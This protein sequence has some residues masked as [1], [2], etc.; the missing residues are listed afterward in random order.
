[1][2]TGAARRVG[3]DI[4]LALAGKGYPMA[5]H[6]RSSRG[7]AE[8]LAVRIRSAGV[9]CETFRADLERAEECARLVRSVER[10][11]G[12]IAVLVNSAS[13]Y[14]G[15]RWD[16]VKRD[17]W[18]RHMHVNARAPFFCAQAA[19]RSMMK[20]GGGKIVNI[21]DADVSRPY[22]RYLPYLVSKNA[23]AGLTL[24][25]AKELAPTVQVNGVSPGAVLLPEGW[26]KKVRDAIIR[27]T[28]ARKIGSPADIAA[29]V[30]FFV[31]SSDFITG[32]IL[33]VDGGRHLR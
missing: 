28:P 30:L 24:C 7:E 3:R 22:A 14:E 27:A 32:A 11:L 25:L 8:K 12:G 13:V 31:E 23:L 16:R 5:L 29:A 15:R 10:K 17:D 26:G 18:D 19:A 20:R 33:P 9:R 1:M 6:Y 2:V 21:I 4:A